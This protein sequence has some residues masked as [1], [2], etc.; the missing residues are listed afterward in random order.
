MDRVNPK[1]N[2]TLTPYIRHLFDNW[3]FKRDFVTFET[4][5]LEM[6]FMNY[7]LKQFL[8]D[9][10]TNK[11]RIRNVKQFLP[12]L[13]HYHD[14]NGILRNVDLE[15]K[16]THI[17]D[18]NDTKQESFCLLYNCQEHDIDYHIVNALEHIHY[19][20][21]KCKGVLREAF[22]MKLI[23]LEITHD[24]FHKTP[25]ELSKQLVSIGISIDVANCCVASVKKDEIVHARTPTDKLIKYTLDQL[26]KNQWKNTNCDLFAQKQAF[27]KLYSKDLN[28]LI[29]PIYKQI[30]KVTAKDLYKVAKEIH[31]FS[32]DTVMKLSKYLYVKMII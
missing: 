25:K 32:N 20:F 4:F 17:K 2:S 6:N 24:S 27:K 30:D 14:I 11:I 10:N 12:N 13:K 16:R 9:E 18:N 21:D 31:M 28:S 5:K 23:Q 22:K 3:C 7:N 29:S 1:Q 26:E 15:L 19:Q 8:F